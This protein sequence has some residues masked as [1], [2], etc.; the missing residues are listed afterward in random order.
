MSE[1]DDSEKTQEA[2]PERRRQARENGQFAKARDTGAMAASFAVLLALGGFGDSLLIKM[3][4]FSVRCFRD[5]GALAGDGLDVAGREAA[6]TLVGLILPILAAAC[7]AGVAAGLWEAGFHPNLEL[8]LPKFERLDPINKLQQMFSPKQSAMSI[9]LSL[10]RV[11]VVGLVAYLVIERELPRLERLSTA[12]LPDAMLAI[13]GVLSKLALWCT[14]ALAVLTA[15]D[16]GQSWMRHEASIRMSLDELK[17]EHKQQE[18][19]PRLKARQR[20][21]ARE[22]MRRGLKKQVLE[23]D[24]VI[25]NPTHIAIAIRYKAAQ[26]APV[27]LAKGFDEVALYMRQIAEEGGVPVIENKP[28]ARALA[29]VRVNRVIPV[30]FYGAVAEV[31]AFVYRLKNRGRRA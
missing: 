3:R 16:Y 24:V 8:A 31:L 29:E 9:A 4:D 18:G 23:S 11:A 27:V 17:R 22:R 2:S 6:F 25:A 14:L 28:L 30:E 5:A 19:D 1:E 20:S 12:R 10:G 21:A 15:L 7:I 13:G 26:G